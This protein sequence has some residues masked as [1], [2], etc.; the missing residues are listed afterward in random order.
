[1]QSKNWCGICFAA[2]NA[3]PEPSPKAA[4]CIKLATRRAVLA[5][6]ISQPLPCRASRRTSSLNH[7]CAMPSSASIPP[8]LPNLTAP[9][10]CCTN[11]GPSFWPCAARG[12]SAPMNC[13]PAGSAMSS[14]CPLAATMSTSPSSSST[15][16]M[17]ARP[18]TTTN[19]CSPPNTSSAPGPPSAAPTWCCWSTA[20][21]WSS[22]RPKPRCAMPS[23][24]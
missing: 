16:T 22:S 20:F 1:M 5:G 17:W 2:N 9:M 19:T 7:T 12:L 10:K 6:S 4:H 15:T 23:V 18:M 8:S 14:P 11:Y 13:S 21:R 24:G 3:L